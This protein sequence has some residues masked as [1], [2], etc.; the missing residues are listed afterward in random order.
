MKRAAILLALLTLPAA[1]QTPVVVVE[2]GYGGQRITAG[3]L[4]N[5]EYTTDGVLL[6]FETDGIFR[7][8][9]D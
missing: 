7:N 3:L 4:R 2:H 8:G 9:F 1:A 5:L 6:E